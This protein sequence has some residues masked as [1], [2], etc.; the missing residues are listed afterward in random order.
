MQIAEKEK[1]QR[2]KNDSPSTRRS[3]FFSTPLPNIYAN[4][5][6]SLRS[7]SMCV[8]I[9]RWCSLSAANACAA[10]ALFC[11]HFPIFVIFVVSRCNAFLG[12][13]DTQRRAPAS[14][15][16]RQRDTRCRDSRAQKK[17]THIRTIAMQP[18][19]QF[20]LPGLSD[21]VFVEHVLG[22]NSDPLDFARIRA[23]SRSMRDALEVTGRCRL[24]M[25]T[26]AHV[27]GRT[28]IYG[29]CAAAYH[30]CLSTLKHL[31]RQGRLQGKENEVFNTA[32]QGGHLEVL[33]WLR[34]VGFQWNERICAFA[35]M[36]GHLEELK[37]LR[38]NGCP[39]DEETCEFAATGGTG[40]H[41]EVLQWARAN[42]CQ[43]G[44]STCVFAAMRGH[45]DVLQWARANG[46]PWISLTCTAAAEGGHL[47]VM[48]WARANGCPDTVSFFFFLG[49]GSKPMMWT[50]AVSGKSDANLDNAERHA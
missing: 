1:L 35:A 19:A 10:D 49:L 17:Q 20:T 48:Q 5:S 30:G 36:G 38:A 27:Y 29:E 15:R 37:W 34:S 7:C 23:V 42:G 45:L 32:S 50:H 26:S 47:E 11:R 2:H 44:T 12:S 41:L 4:R 40:G 6:R 25:N 9:D 43:W 18:E 3:A 24:V 46:C 22:S 28:R 8:C 39:W 14:P 21:H 13:P 33:K 16:I 31:H